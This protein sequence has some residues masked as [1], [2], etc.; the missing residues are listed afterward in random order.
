MFQFTLPPQDDFLWQQIRS[1][2]G[3]EHRRA[4]LKP[5]RVISRRGYE[6]IPWR[7]LPACEVAAS[8]K[9]TPRFSLEQSIVGR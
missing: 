1:T 8:W 7:K 6:K 2:E 4:H 9:L 5:M 3:D